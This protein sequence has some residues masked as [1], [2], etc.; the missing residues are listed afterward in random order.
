ML[1]SGQAGN[2]MPY[3]CV[4]R[5]K[6]VR[7]VDVPHY[8]SLGIAFGIAVAADMVRGFDDLNGAVAFRERAGNGRP[9]MPT[10]AYKQ[11]HG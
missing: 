2:E 5:M 11:P 1:R 8:A 9:D 3:A 10:P 6:D 7:P 4:V